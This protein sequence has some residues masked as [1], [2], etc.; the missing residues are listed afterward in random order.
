MIASIDILTPAA[1]TATINACVFFW[2]CTDILY[3]F[4]GKEIA[5]EAQFNLYEEKGIEPDEWPD[6]YHRH[7]NAQA[8]IMALSFVLLFLS[9]LIIFFTA[10]Q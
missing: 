7:V 1:I 4:F 3:F 2:A 5:M 8:V 10:N 6:R 9:T